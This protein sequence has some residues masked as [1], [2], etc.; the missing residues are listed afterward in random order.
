MATHTWPDL[1]LNVIAG[2]WNFSEAVVVVSAEGT[3]DTGA[4]HAI[5]GAAAAA[6]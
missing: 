1:E 3:G 2:A 5:V 4:D 6:I